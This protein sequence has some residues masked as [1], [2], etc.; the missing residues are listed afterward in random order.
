MDEPIVAPS[1]EVI[2]S[3]A[4]PF[5]KPN[6]VRERSN[7]L[8]AFVVYKDK[9]LKNS[10][11][12]SEIT[13]E[14]LI[15]IAGRS[16]QFVNSQ[17]KSEYAKL[18]THSRLGFR[19]LQI[20]DPNISVAARVAFVI[21]ESCLVAALPPYRFL[22]L[23]NKAFIFVNSEE[24][25]EITIIRRC[26]HD[27]YNLLSDSSSSASLSFEQSM[28][29]LLF[30]AVDMYTDKKIFELQTAYDAF[31]SNR[32]D[33][34]TALN[35]QFE[36]LRELE[37]SCEELSSSIQSLLKLLEELLNNQNDLFGMLLT[38][39]LI[40][41]KS[42]INF[43]SQDSNELKKSLPKEPGIEMDDVISDKK[44][45]EELLE[46]FDTECDINMSMVS[47]IKVQVGN[48]VNR[49]NVLLSSV[50]NKILLVNNFINIASAVF[51]ACTVV[52]AWMALNLGNGICGPQGCSTGYLNPSGAG[53]DAYWDGFVPV[54]TI[55]SV[56][57]VLIGLMLWSYLRH[58]VG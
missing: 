54:T 32:S 34:S 38:R 42:T 16:I 31:V 3:R 19:D 49:L 18:F 47:R 57:A 15:S 12:L 29:S 9:S 4:N 27:Y 22:I 24:G 14:E 36:Q 44:M 11:A 46:W 39:K 33:N 23:P 6:L 40:I 56:I 8:K 20:I 51:G 21:R 30:A 10:F 50:N 13:K 48:Q 17:N 28:L 35:L 2:F 55:S 26:V 25:E 58:V 5:L 41:S 53:Y 45:M 7:I 43:S 37:S 52:G 1:R